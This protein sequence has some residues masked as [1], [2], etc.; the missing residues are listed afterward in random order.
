MKSTYIKDGYV[1][2]KKEYQHVCQYCG[3]EFI[4]YKSMQKVC[5]KSCSAKM[6]RNNSMNDISLF[7]NSVNSEIKAYAL[8]LICS[9]GCISNGKLSINLNDKDILELLHP[10]MTPEKKLYKQRSNYAVISNNKQDIDFLNSIGVTERKTYDITIPNIDEPYIRHMIRGWFDGDGCAYK[11]TTINKKYNYSKTYV[12]VSFTTGSI[13]FAEELQQ[14]LLQYG[15]D[16]NLNKDCRRDT[17]YVKVVKQE[18]IK[19]FYDWIYTD[20]TIYM[21]RKKDK[22]IGMI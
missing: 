20:A 13:K 5:S 19:A 7:N 2:N 22:F 14:L 6:T 12:Y 16:S 8:G 9:D 10:L 1:C 21:Q 17:Y 3:K 11:S 15:I 4:S 18:S